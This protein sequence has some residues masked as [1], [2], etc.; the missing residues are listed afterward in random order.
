METIKNYLESMFRN[1][2]NTAKVLKAKNEL[3]QM[4]EDK[5]SELRREGKTEN[6]AVATVIAEFGNLDE[7]AASLGIKEE[8]VGDQAPARRNVSFDEIKSYLKD[9]FTAIILTSIAIG[10]FISC[11]VPVIVMSNIFHKDVA[12]VVL[13]FVF[14]AL[15]VA[16]MIVK[17]SIM[18][19]WSFLKSQPCSIG[20]DTTEF[21]IEEKRKFRS[22]Y[23][24]LHS[25]GCCLCICCCVPVIITDVSSLY[26]VQELGPVLFF[27]FI[28]VGVGLIVYSNSRNSVYKRLLNIN[29]ETTIGGSYAD[30]KE[31][32]P[33]YK[34]KT[35]RVIM[36][37]YWPVITCIYLSFSFLTF[38]WWISWIIW[39]IAGVLQR[40]IVALA[41][42]E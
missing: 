10:F 29:S 15:G 36:S 42:E 4:M 16:L 32:A 38:Q 11:C 40:V 7:V 12:G 30:P 3:L 18:E 13:L 25:I 5:Y 9:K 17:G 37:V 31:K 34:N 14:V 21:L 26:R 22:I 2:P 19:P 41:S 20:P 28:S 35:V 6:E 27:L 24:L 33:V 39:P 23:A 8:I 1:L